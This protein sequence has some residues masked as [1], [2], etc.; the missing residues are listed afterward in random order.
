MLLLA[1]N[2]VGEVRE[3]EGGGSSTMPQKSNPIRAEALVTLARRNATL[4]GGMHQAMLHAQERDGAAWQLEWAILPDMVDGHGARPWRM[5]ASS[6][7]RWSSTPRGCAAMLDAAR[8]LP[9]AEAASFVLAEH[10][11]RAEAQELVKQ[12]SREV[13]TSGKD[14][15]QI[16]AER[17]ETKID[18]RQLASRRRAAGLRRRSDRSGARGGSGRERGA[19]A[20]LRVECWAKPVPAKF[21]CVRSRSTSNVEKHRRSTARR[22]LDDILLPPCGNSSAQSIGHSAVASALTCPP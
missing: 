1:Q 4:V 21:L 14:L 13:M 5:R 17:V 20:A 10:L 8:G 2:E 9:L 22:R 11:P 18:W 15:L 7:A 3:A 6:P 16:V 12:A 19:A